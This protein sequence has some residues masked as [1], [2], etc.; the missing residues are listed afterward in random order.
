MNFVVIGSINTDFVIN[1]DRMPKVGETIKGSGFLSNNGGK[2]AN[3][4]IAAAK[5]GG[6]VTFIGAV[7]NDING[8]NA[9]DNLDK[10]HINTQRIERTSTNTGAAVITVCDGDNCIILDSGA[11]DLVTKEVIDK[12][13]DI[14]ARADAVIMQLEI[15]MET[16][17]Y[18]AQKAHEAGVKV[19]LNPAPITMLPKQLTD[20]TD[21]II[22]NETETEY[23]TKVY[24]DTDENRKKCIN[25][26]RDKGIDLVIITLGADGSIYNLDDQII[27]Q[28]AYKTKAVDTTAA[29]DTF[30]GAFCMNIDKGLKEA[31]KYATAASAITVSRPGASSSIPNKEEIETFLQH[32]AVEKNDDI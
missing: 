17:A 20:N 21:V 10:N 22:L 16:V 30:I 13:M 7:G 28:K 27:H 6:D 11:N 32:K 8:I 4:A 23:L 29:G 19:V 3:Q 15:P 12:N 18:A 31:V 5:L 1:T 9:I 14:I 2:G 26:I 24:P 25:I